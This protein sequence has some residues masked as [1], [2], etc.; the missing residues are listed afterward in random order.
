LNIRGL[1]TS[2]PPAEGFLAG[3]A[4]SKFIKNS[5]EQTLANPELA[6]VLKTKET[7]KLNLCQAVNESLHLALASD[8]KAG[9]CFFTFARL[10]QLT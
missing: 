3:V 9:S 7:K 6:K 10:Y 4:D 1:A 2:P 5:T 8:D